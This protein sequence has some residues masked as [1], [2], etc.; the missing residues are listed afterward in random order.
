MFLLSF[1]NGK[2]EKSNAYN[3]PAALGG[4]IVGTIILV[5]KI[6][7]LIMAIFLLQGAMEV[8]KFNQA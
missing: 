8:N 1:F 6:L 7:Q 3:F 5:V 2:N 4:L